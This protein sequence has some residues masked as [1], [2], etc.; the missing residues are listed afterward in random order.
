[1]G[2]SNLKYGDDFI[3]VDM[4]KPV[5]TFRHDSIKHL[6]KEAYIQ[7]REELYGQYDLLIN[8]LYSN[9]PYSPEMEREFRQNLNMMMEP[10]LAKFYQMVEPQFFHRFF[11]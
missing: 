7:K 9:E 6:N 11:D 3:D 8:S 2:F 4:T 5:G 10:S 1:V